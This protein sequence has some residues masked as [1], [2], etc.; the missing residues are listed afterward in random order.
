MGAT[1]GEYRMLVG[2]PEENI[3]LGRLRRGQNNNI[4]PYPADVEK[5]VSS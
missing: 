5:I 4:N 2:R 3:P 1:K